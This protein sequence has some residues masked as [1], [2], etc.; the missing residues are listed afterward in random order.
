STTTTM[1]KTSVSGPAPSEVPLALLTVVT[2]NPLPLAVSQGSS[3]PSAM[4]RPPMSINATRVRARPTSAIFVG[5]VAAGAAATGGG[6][7]APSFVA[8]S[9]GE[10]F[11]AICVVTVGVSSAGSVAPQ[12]PQ[13]RF[14]AVASAPH[15]GQYIATPSS[16]S[17]YAP[18][19]PLRAAHNT[20][21]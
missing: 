9:L 3:A 19:N 10:R 14:P 16:S 8:G 12:V 6:V 20:Q 17:A 13:N 7:A 11:G 5:A 4:R 18:T 1:P 2:P 15:D 21:P